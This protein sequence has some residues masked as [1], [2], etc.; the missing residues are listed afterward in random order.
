MGKPLSC[1][2]RWRFPAINPLLPGNQYVVLGAFVDVR[3]D[4]IYNFPSTGGH[5]AFYPSGFDAKDSLFLKR[6]RINSEP[7]I[8][9]DVSFPGGLPY[10]SCPDTSLVLPTANQFLSQGTE[11]HPYEW[12]DVNTFLPI[13]Q[14]ANGIVMPAIYCPAIALIYNASALQ[15]AYF[16]GTVSID[17]EWEHTLPL[18]GP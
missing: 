1:G 17:A 10:F 18:I 2:T 9:Q 7:G 14:G 12:N 16:A 15:V 13:T 8:L 4:N 5:A 3:A 11:L 6:W